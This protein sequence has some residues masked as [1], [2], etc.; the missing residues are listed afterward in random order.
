MSVIIKNSKLK[1]KYGRI[2][3]DSLTVAFFTSFHNTVTTVLCVRHLHV[4]IHH[5]LMA[6]C[7]ICLITLVA[8]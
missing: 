1:Q 7:L 5:S 2:Y 8:F 6:T 4:I 3:L